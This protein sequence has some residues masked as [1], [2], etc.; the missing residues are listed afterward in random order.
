MSLELAVTVGLAVLQGLLAL[1]MRQHFA[2]LRA[3]KEQSTELKAVVENQRKERDTSCRECQA[4][5][6]REDQALSA[7]MDETKESLEKQQLAQTTRLDRA[8][9]TM[10]KEYV[11]KDDYIRTLASFDRKLDKLVGMVSRMRRERRET[12]SEEVEPT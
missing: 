8:L 7:S 6:E 9:E 3:M 1:V 4:R 5:F 12:S 11:L 10:P 2:E